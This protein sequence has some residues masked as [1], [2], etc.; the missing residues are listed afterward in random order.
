M[1]RLAIHVNAGPFHRL[2]LLPR[3]GRKDVRRFWDNVV[4]GITHTMVM[5]PVGN[6]VFLFC[7]Q[8]LRNGFSINESVR[9]TYDKFGCLCS[10]N[11]LFWPPMNFLAY[12]Y[13]AL[14]YR[15]HFFAIGNY[16]YSVVVSYLN[17]TY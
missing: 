12:H 14:H 4:K 10:V 11:M 5:G 6:A 1:A 7:S 17:N 3:S 15:M 2:G 9:H 8:M 16:F 13:M